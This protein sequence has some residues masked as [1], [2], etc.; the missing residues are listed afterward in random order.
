MEYKDLIMPR[1]Q[2]DY[3]YEYV[4]SVERSS[5][6]PTIFYLKGLSVLDFRKC[7]EYSS[8]NSQIGRFNLELL[9]HGL[10]G[11]DNLYWKNSDSHI[12]FDLAN[13]A[14]IPPSAQNE[15]A[16]KILRISDVE[17][18]LEED[19]VFVSRWSDYLG[20]INNSDQWSCEF[21]ISKKQSG[22]R[23]C[24]GTKPNRCI[25][26]KIETNEEE[27]PECGRKTVPHFKMK[28]GKLPLALTVTRC[29]VSMLSPIA[30]KLTNLI[31]FMEN[32]KSLPTSGGALEQTN[33]FY[34]AR[35]IVMSE[36]NMLLKNERDNLAS[37]PTKRSLRK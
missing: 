35:M 37:E 18:K 11:W 23:N 7:E 32:S 36:Q 16:A 3:I 28:I 1:L 19:L 20:K 25:D 34:T 22:I 33:F 14:A 30:I 21:C 2:P 24:D 6:N 5:D 15:L 17:D 9:R 29:P 13:I 31:N 12:P 8:G 10:V 26:C 4:C 27:C